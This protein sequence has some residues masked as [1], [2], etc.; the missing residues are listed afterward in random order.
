MN[1]KSTE[2][3]HLTITLNEDSNGGESIDLRTTATIETKRIGT[4]SVKRE[5]ALSQSITLQS[6][7][8]SAELQ[9]WYDF[10]PKRLREIADKLDE[11]ILA[12]DLSVDG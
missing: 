5:V 10:S 3:K 11:W 12:N 6:Y 2:H 4:D 7:G 9:L 1:Q 8:R